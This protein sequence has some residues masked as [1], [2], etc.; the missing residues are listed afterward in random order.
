MSIVV[1]FVIIDVGFVV[2]LLFFIVLG[3]VVVVIGVVYV[4][5]VIGV[6]YIVVVAGCVRFQ[7]LFLVVMYLVINSMNF[8]YF[9][10]LDYNQLY[11]FA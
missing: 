9:H 8:L 2:V 7:L 5:V 10:N 11:L 3:F 6:G 4:V 1:G